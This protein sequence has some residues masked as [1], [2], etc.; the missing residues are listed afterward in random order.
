MCA[1]VCV[2]VCVCVCV[3]THACIHM[4]ECFS[5]LCFFTFHFSH[6]V[7]LVVYCTFFQLKQYCHE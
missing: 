2:C 5:L 3:H 4:S 7:V 6:T 1:L